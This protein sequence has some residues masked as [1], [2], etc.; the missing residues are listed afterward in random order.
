MGKTAL[1]KHGAA[2]QTGNGNSYRV[3]IAKSKV[4]K[5]IDT[6]IGFALSR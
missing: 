4:R 3:S 6:T 5:N 2:V 1:S